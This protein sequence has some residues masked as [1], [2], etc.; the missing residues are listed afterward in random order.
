MWSLITDVSSTSLPGMTFSPSIPSM[1]GTCPGQVPQVSIRAPG[2]ETSPCPDS[3]WSRSLLA[4]GC[5]FG[6]VRAL[7]GFRGDSVLTDGA[8]TGSWQGGH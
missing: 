3:H 1:A 5:P 2:T 4:D 8:G 7:Q 6:V